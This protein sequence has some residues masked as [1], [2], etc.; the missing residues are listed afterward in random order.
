MK[1]ESTWNVSE[2]GKILNI[3]ETTRKHAATVFISYPNSSSVEP[4]SIFIPKLFKEISGI[5]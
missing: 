3:E 1:S 4:V 2:S 5:N